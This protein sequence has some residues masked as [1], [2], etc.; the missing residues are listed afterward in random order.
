MDLVVTIL[1]M[2]LLRDHI[3][4]DEVGFLRD[5]IALDKIGVSLGSYSSW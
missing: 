1:R 5:H 3:A 2:N 4:L